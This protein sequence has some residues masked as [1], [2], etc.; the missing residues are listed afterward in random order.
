MHCVKHF[1]SF[2]LSFFLSHSVCVCVYFGILRWRKKRGFLLAVYQSRMQWIN[3]RN[4][5]LLLPPSNFLSEK[6]SMMEY[7][8]MR[9]ASGG[10]GIRR[11]RRANLPWLAPVTIR[12]RRGAKFAVRL[13]SEIL[14]SSFWCCSHTSTFR[15]QRSNKN[16]F[17][18]LIFYMQMLYWDRNARS[19]SKNA[20]AA[21]RAQ[22]AEKMQRCAQLEQQR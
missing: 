17:F 5:R 9:T 8:S 15:K 20:L 16:F 12:R 7:I 21:N 1:L 18:I 3:P 19:A 2:F 10:Q 4:I 6:R 13:Q 11:L 14:L 22:S